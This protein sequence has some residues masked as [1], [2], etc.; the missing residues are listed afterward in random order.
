M[1]RRDIRRWDLLALVLNS[2]IGAGIFGLPSRAYALA[3]AY[4]VAAYVVC[5]VPVLLIVLCLAEVSSRFN[6]TGGLYLYARSAFGPF[7]GFQIGYFAWLSR[8]TALAAVSNLFADYL[9]YF[10]P[11]V[12]SGPMRA[13]MITMAIGFLAAANIAGVRLASQFS[14]L[15]TIG[16]VVPLLFLL[17]A[18]LFYIDPQ[19]YSFTAVPGYS[20]FSTSVLIL[21]FA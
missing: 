2:V 9:S 21:L 7:V 18:G 3:G 4:S 13:A 10:V 6:E 12:Q 14:D 1:L 17:V 5:I 19:R 11:V 8:M 16:K 15:F 20:N